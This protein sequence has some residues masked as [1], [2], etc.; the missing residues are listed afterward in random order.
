MS[1]GNE[2]DRKHEDSRIM[3]H[4]AENDDPASRPRQEKHA[5]RRV[6]RRLAST[7]GGSANLDK[8]RV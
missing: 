6:R 2:R 1:N 7:T 5:Q 8:T 4:L 3:D